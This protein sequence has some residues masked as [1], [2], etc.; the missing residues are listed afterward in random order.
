MG[1]VK[2]AC[3]KGMSTFI[4]PLLSLTGYGVQKG[5]RLVSPNHTVV[6][7]S[8]I[9]SGAIIGLVAGIVVTVILHPI[10]VVVAANDAI[11]TYKI[12]SPVV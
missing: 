3:G 2:K 8:F 11:K 5:D 6:N 7:V 4:S 10:L 12:K 1:R 9:V